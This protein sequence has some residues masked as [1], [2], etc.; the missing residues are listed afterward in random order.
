VVKIIFTP[1]FAVPRQL[2][3]DAIDRQ[4]RQ[5]QA[6]DTPTVQRKG[7]HHISIP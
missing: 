5:P 3:L 4:A 2:P 6:E 1:P 7:T